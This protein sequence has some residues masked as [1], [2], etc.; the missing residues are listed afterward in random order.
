[1]VSLF[2]SILCLLVRAF[3]RALYSLDKT[4]TPVSFES[5]HQHVFAKFESQLSQRVDVLLRFLLKLLSGSKPVS[6][7]SSVWSGWRVSKLGCCMTA[8]QPDLEKVT[9]ETSKKQRK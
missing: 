8:T 1:M 6:C 7:C 3:V 4:D 9:G 5:R 2:Y